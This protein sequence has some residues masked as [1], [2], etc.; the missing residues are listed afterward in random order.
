MQTS[1][2][3]VTNIL[4]TRSNSWVTTQIKCLCHITQTVS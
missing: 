4:G 3:L 2:D 1:Q